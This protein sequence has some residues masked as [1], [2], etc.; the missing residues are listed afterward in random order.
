MG[1]RKL[2]ITT[3][4]LTSLVTVSKQNSGFSRRFRIVSGALPDDVRVVAVEA[5]DPFM[6]RLILESNEWETCEP[7]AVQ[8]PPIFET[9]FD[10]PAPEGE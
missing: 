5:D 1:Q 8:L 7:M 6:L 2:F 10:D 9:V 4:L 3:E